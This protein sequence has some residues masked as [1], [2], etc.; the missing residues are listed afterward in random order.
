MKGSASYDYEF[1]SQNDLI[2]FEL[3]HYN[4][5][6]DKGIVLATWSS[7]LIVY[8]ITENISKATLSFELPPPKGTTFTDAIPDMGKYWGLADG[9]LM[10]F[11]PNQSD[12]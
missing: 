3:C 10:A 7:I 11:R 6:E 12:Y 4:K 8:E 2:K 1:A 9:K 5:R